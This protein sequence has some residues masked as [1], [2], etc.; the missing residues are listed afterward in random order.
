MKLKDIVKYIDDSI[1]LKI[2]D[3]KI[4]IWYKGVEDE[5][6]DNREIKSIKLDNSHEHII[7][8]LN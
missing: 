3:R 1:L 5:L 8:E 2:P 4:L 6:Y 7:I